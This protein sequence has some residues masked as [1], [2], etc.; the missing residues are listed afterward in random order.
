MTKGISIAHVP[1]GPQKCVVFTLADGT[2]L[3]VRTSAKGLL[4]TSCTVPRGEI[5]MLVRPVGPREVVI[6]LV[7]EDD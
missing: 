3:A 7:D 1:G 5:S 2:V 4:V 6:A